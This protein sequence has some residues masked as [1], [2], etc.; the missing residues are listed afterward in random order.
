MNSILIQHYIMKVNLFPSM[1]KVGWKKQEIIFAKFVKIFFL[2]ARRAKLPI[3]YVTQSRSFIGFDSQYVRTL[4][5]LMV[6]KNI[7][8]RKKIIKHE[9][10]TELRFKQYSNEIFFENLK[11]KLVWN[12]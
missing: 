11:A 4:N 12:N 10:F 1:I 9:K 7:L 8:M 2:I 5:I 3:T 6:M